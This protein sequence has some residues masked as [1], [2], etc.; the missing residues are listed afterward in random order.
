MLRKNDTESA[1]QL[2]ADFSEGINWLLTVEKLMQDNNYVIRSRVEEV[3]TYA[4]IISTLLE[5]QKNE[6]IALIFEEKIAP[7]FISAS[8]WIFTKVRH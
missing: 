6:E 1:F 7:L 2:I 5:Q 8:E 4:S 3:I